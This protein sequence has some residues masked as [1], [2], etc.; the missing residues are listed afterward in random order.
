MPALLL[1]DLPRFECL[2]E[3]AR[4]NPTLDPSA[5]VAYLHLLRAGDEAFAA[6]D[7]NFARFELSHGRF[8]VLMLLWRKD[9]YGKGCPE[10]GPEGRTPADLAAAAGVSRATMTGLI[11]TLER[12]G[13]VTRQPDQQDRRMMLVQ[14]TDMG[15]DLMARLL[16]LH[17]QT[18]AEMLS[19]LDESER[20]TL[21]QLLARLSR[22]RA[23]E[24]SP[25]SGAGP[26]PSLILSVSEK[27]S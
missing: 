16:P 11:D 2:L 8:G 10:I 20:Q 9:K 21:V 14:M 24:A 3:A 13:M 23:A 17:F 15:R 18:V 12:D 5:V 19:P 4:N 25:L 1:K 22:P 7:R 6:A 27:T 26:T